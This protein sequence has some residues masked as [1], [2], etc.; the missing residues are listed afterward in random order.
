MLTNFII[1]EELFRRV[2]LEQRWE[3]ALH[4]FDVLFD[5][6]MGGAVSDHVFTTERRM[7]L[8]AFRCLSAKR[9]AKI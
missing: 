2:S 4:F 5:A 7:A 1:L 9:L 8:S 6:D 3:E